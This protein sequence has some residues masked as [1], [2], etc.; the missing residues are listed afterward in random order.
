MQSTRAGKSKSETELKVGH[1]NVVLN[2]PWLRRVIA[3]L[4][5]VQNLSV[6]VEWKSNRGTWLESKNFQRSRAMYRRRKTHPREH[7]LLFN[8]ELALLIFVPSSDQQQRHLWRWCHRLPLDRNQEHW[9]WIQMFSEWINGY[10]H[11]SIKR[12]TNSWHRN[13]KEWRIH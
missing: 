3:D 6:V 2:T 11:S 10:H 4:S 9:C 12:S 1:L 5:K 8:G 7:C 13:S